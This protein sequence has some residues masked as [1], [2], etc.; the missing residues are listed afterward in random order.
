M[1]KNDHEFKGKNKVSKT[2]NFKKKKAQKGQSKDDKKDP[3]W[4]WGVDDH[5]SPWCPN[6]YDREKDPR[7][8]SKSVNMIIG[9]AEGEHLSMVIY[10]LPSIQIKLC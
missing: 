5:W 3:C 9:N 8:S 6:Y 4:V 7:K 10:L 1:Q 2:T